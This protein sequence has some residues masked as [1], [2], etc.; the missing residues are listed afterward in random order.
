M[1][2]A[3]RANYP[4]TGMP[5]VSLF[6]SVCVAALHLETAEEVVRV[7]IRSLDAG[8]RAYNVQPQTAAIRT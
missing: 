6:V 1:L 7:H 8:S 4:D 2:V 3:G 5:F